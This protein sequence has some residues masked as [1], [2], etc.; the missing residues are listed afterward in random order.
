MTRKIMRFSS[1]NIFKFR[2]WWNQNEKMQQSAITWFNK[3]WQFLK[4]ECVHVSKSSYQ[5]HFQL[6]LHPGTQGPPQGIAPWECNWPLEST[7]GLPGWLMYGPF[8]HAGKLLAP[9]IALWWKKLQ[10]WVTG[11]PQWL[12]MLP[13]QTWANI[14]AEGLTWRRHFDGPLGFWSNMQS[15]QH[16]WGWLTDR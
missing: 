5:T 12:P 14:L 10:L 15:H 13:Q 7:P 16:M 11:W 2:V 4:H 6:V 8:S 9:R 3:H 1:F